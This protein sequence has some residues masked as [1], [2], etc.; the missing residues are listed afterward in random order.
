M[1]ELRRFHI[2][3]DH[4]AFE[5]HFAGNPILPGVALLSLV[6]QAVGARDLAHAVPQAKFLAP[7]R[8]GTS[9][10]LFTEAAAD[11]RVRFELRDGT[12]CVACG[13]IVV[14]ADPTP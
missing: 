8:P 4:P 11:G 14:G 7:V 9:L 5:G 12:R 1:N 13:A 10:A 6:A 2:A 3:A